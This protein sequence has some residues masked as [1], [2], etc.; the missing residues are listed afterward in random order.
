MDHGIAYQLQNVGAIDNRGWEMQA[1]SSSGPLSLS[2]T[3][4][5]VSSRVRRLSPGYRGDLRPGDRMLEVPARTFGLGAAWTAPRWSLSATA[6]R[7]SDWVNYDRLALATALAATR[8]SDA[9]YYDAFV[10]ARLREFWRSYGGVTHVGVRASLR[11]GRSSALT[12]TGDNL[13]N[14]QLGEPDNVTVLPGRTVTLG[15]RAGF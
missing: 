15:V 8:A 6:A 11:L 3:L 13:L 9:P 1:T 10:G 14:R 7:A 12:L 2:A 4:S 5:L